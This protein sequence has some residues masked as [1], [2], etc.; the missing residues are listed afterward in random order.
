[1]AN[2]CSWKTDLQDRFTNPCFQAIVTMSKASVSKPT[3]NRALWVDWEVAD[4]DDLLLHFSAAAA[5]EKVRLVAIDCTE[6]GN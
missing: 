5:S 6:G 2:T 3:G 1:M 4:E